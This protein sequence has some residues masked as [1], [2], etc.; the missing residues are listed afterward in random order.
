MRSERKEVL[1]I[2]IL[3]LIISLLITATSSITAQ[4]LGITFLA[5][6]LWSLYPKQH[7]LSSIIIVALLSVFQAAL[8]ISEFM[9]SLFASYGGSGLWIIISGFILA[10]AMRTSGLARRIA[11]WITASLSANA[12][13]IVF[14]V[15]IVSLA[16]APLSPST[17]A[18]AFLL[19]PICNSLVEALSVEKGKSR[20]GTGVMLMA[21]TANNICATGF[22][23]S[24]VPNS[25]SSI[26]IKDATGISFSWFDWFRMAFPLTLILLFLSWLICRWMFRPET[27][28]GSETLTCI[29]NLR[30]ELGPLSSKEIVVAVVFSTAVLLWITERFHRLNAGLISLALCGIL[31]IPR[32]GVLKM[33]GVAK[34]TPWG[35]ISL[36]IASI[37]LARAV[38]RWRAFDS[39]AWVIFRALNVERLSHYHFLLLVI[40]VS[41][42]L[43]VVFTSTTVYATVMI[44]LTIALARL[45]DIQ[46]QLIAIPIAFLAPLSVI[47]P[48]NTIPNIVFYSSGCFSQKQMITYGLLVSLLSVVLVLAVGLPY[49][50]F[51]GLIQT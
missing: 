16:V 9:N 38:G 25:I 41:M 19:L 36:F 32:I 14:S 1:V 51:L 2:L 12:N 8:S 44:P 4:I 37:F 7:F 11:L 26:Y 46:P 35:S 5:L 45:H 33:R 49:W 13:T 43:H 22:L 23:T 48:V 15:A 3:T 42:L 24:T 21:M 6:V 30:R 50:N 29:S 20:Y 17:T 28:S 47:L 39:A 18:K 27:V 40:L 10:E 34:Q 31:L